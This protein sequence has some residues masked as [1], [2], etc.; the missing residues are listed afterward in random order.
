M[1]AKAAS[2]C[3]ALVDKAEHVDDAPVGD[4]PVKDDERFHDELSNI[5]AVELGDGAGQAMRPDLQ[6]ISKLL[7]P[8]THLETP[9]RKLGRTRALEELVGVLS[10]RHERP[11]ASQPRPKPCRPRGIFLQRRQLAPLYGRRKKCLLSALSRFAHASLEDLLGNED[12][13]PM[14]F[15]IMR[16]T[17]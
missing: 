15:S 2:P 7:N 13:G 17:F 5:G 6:K 1:P 8:A 12:V 10:L 11:P 14:P 9:A 16:I 3:G 4:E